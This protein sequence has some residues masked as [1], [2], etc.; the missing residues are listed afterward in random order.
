MVIYKTNLIYIYAI[1]L[2]FS[3]FSFQSFGQ[4]P[5]L[6]SSSLLDNWKLEFKTGAGTIITPVPDKY[7]K[8]INNVNIPLFTPGPIGII[9]IKKSITSHFEMGYQFDYMRIQGNVMV[10]NTDVKVLT[11]TYNHSYLI[12]YNFRKTNEFRPLLNYILYYKVGAI[13]LKNDPLGQLPEGFNNADPGSQGKFI[14]NVAILTGIGAGINYQLNTN[15]SLTGS[16]DVN[17]SSDAVEDIYQ[18][19]KLFYQSSHT[20]NSYIAF[21]F[22]VSYSFKF[23]KQ[24]VSNFYN[25]K[26]ETDKNLLLSK[27]AR[28][29]GRYSAANHSVWFNYKKAHKSTK[30]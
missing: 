23:A 26:T 11:Q 25:P 24:K 1:I 12:L 17:R 7:I 14:S 6:K 15:F 5:K 21:S 16:L 9:S 19:H 18:I 8:K 2:M 28:K 4:K 13:S 20:V 10:Q 30:K 3:L 29:K 27:I 22:G